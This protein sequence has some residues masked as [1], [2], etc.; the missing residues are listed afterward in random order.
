[1]IAWPSPQSEPTRPNDDLDVSVLFDVALREIDRHQNVPWRP[2]CLH[3]KCNGCAY[4]ERAREFVETVRAMA[5]ERDSPA[6]T[7]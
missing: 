4:L 2:V 7:P 3:C 1:M 6:A 5:A